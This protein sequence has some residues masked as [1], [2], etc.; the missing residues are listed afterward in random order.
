MAVI[1]KYIKLSVLLL[2]SICEL[3]SRVTV[4]KE[5]Q[6][7][8]FKMWFTKQTTINFTSDQSIKLNS[9]IQQHF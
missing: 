1:V 8:L 7:K 6:K 2:N 3:S 9:A 4:Q 5:N